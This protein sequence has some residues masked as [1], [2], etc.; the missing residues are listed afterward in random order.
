MSVPLANR[1]PWEEKQDAVI[2]V[3]FTDAQGAAHGFPYTSLSYVVT[4]GAAVV[5]NIGAAKVTITFP[6][7]TG[8]TLALDLLEAFTEQRV[9]RVDHSKEEG[10]PVDVRVEFP[11]P[12]ENA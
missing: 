12:E 9:R 4:E 2:G 10:C 8:G 1:K 5:L 11:E 6:P 7:S 3:T